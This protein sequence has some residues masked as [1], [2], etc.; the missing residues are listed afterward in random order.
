MVM[1]VGIKKLH[2]NEWLVH[3]G[4]AKIKMDRFSVELLNIT[5]EHLSMLEHGQ[6]HSNVKSYIKLGLRLQQLDDRNLQKI[7]SAVDSLDLLNLLL[8]ASNPSFSQRVLDNIGGILAKQL[9]SDLETTPVPDEALIFKSI[10]S[11]VEKMFAM[12]E[13]GNIE[14]IKENTQYI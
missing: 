2:E 9:R 7:L 6:K 5:L 14:F 1:Q 12:E 8:A 10:Q 3:V 13:S 4:C 11:I